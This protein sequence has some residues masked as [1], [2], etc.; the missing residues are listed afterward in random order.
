MIETI[1]DAI[2]FAM[3]LEQDLF[4]GMLPANVDADDDAYTVSAEVPG[5]TEDNIDI[6]YKQDVLTIKASYGDGDLRHGDYSRSFTF[7]DVD[8]S[9]IEATLK[10]G[11]LTITLR[12][13]EEK[14]A[15][16]INIIKGE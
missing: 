7:R 12:K 16:K 6:D 15:R 8:S 9:K 5:L 2:N 14:K 3:D 11:I 1:N 13:A 4:T 10:D